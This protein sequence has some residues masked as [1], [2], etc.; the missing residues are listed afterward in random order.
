MTKGLGAEEAGLTLERG[1]I[2]VDELFAPACPGISAIGDVITFDQPGHPQLAHLSSAEGV[3]LAERIAGHEFR[4][5]NYDQV[6]GCT[7]CDPEIGSVGLTE[8][9]AQA[10]G[11]EVKIGTF[12]FGILGRA[13]IAGEVEGFVKIVFDKKYD[14]MLGVHLI[15]PRATEL[16]AEA[17]LALRLECTVEELIRTIHAHPTMSEAIGE[18]RTPRTAGRFTPDA[19]V[20]LRVTSGRLRSRSGTCGWPR[21]APR[22][23]RSAGNRE[24]DETM[25]TNVVMPQMGESIAEGTIVRWIKKIGDEVDRDEPLFEISTDKVDAEIPSPAAGVLTAIKAKEGETVPVN[26]VV[27]VIGGERGASGR[28]R[29]RRSTAPSLPPRRDGPA[30]PEPQRPPGGRGRRAA[31]PRRPSASPRPQTSR[32]RTS[33]AARN[34]RRWCAA[35]P[36]APGRHR[37][38]PRHRHRRPGHQ[39]GH[40][41]LHRAR[42]QPAAPAA[43][44]HRAQEAGARRH[45]SSRAS[46]SASC[47]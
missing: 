13:R 2:K 19:P 1:Y 4:P 30:E 46:A 37:L 35:S 8:K 22:A 34:R 43:A 15:G 14:E 27:A 44:R 36:G 10:R 7:Y 47:R 26:S 3:A 9:E 38:D 24:L 23:T 17:T 33:F 40:P 21:A 20:Q 42:R 12:K 18:A 5:I 6:P 39:A 11:Y 16:V 29:P 41:R 32:A 45:R 28:R 31:K 25:P